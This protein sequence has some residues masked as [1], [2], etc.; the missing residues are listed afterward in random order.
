MIERTKGKHVFFLV[1]FA[2]AIALIGGGGIASSEYATI[3]GESPEECTPIDGGE[4]ETFE[5]FVEYDIGNKH[6][7]RINVMVKEDPYGEPTKVID[8]SDRS[9]QDTVSIEVEE[10]IDPDWESITLKATVYAED[11]I[12]ASGSDEVYYPVSGSGWTCDPDPERI[13]GQV[14]DGDGNDPPAGIV[15]VQSLDD[16]EQEIQEYRTDSDCP[17]CFDFDD[18]SF[19]TPGEYR[20]HVYGSDSGYPPY[21]GYMDFTLDEG[22]S[23]FVSFE[24]GGVFSTDLRVTDESG[25]TTDLRFGPGEDVQT[26]LDVQ[27]PRHG[28]D[29][30][31]EMY[32]YETGGERGSHPDE[33]Y[34]PP[35]LGAG[36][37]SYE[38]TFDAPDEEGTYEVKYR[39]VTEF[40]DG[41]ESTTDIVEGP[42][43]EV[44]A[45]EPPHIEESTPESETV[46]I[47]AKEDLNFSVTASDPDTPDE[48]LSVVWTVDDQRVAS[49]TSF[50]FDA[51]AYE[52]GDHDVRVLVSDGLDRTEDVE[53]IWT[54]EVIEPPQIEDVEPG[55]AEVLAGEQ[56]ILRAEATDPGDHTPLSYTWRID[57]KTYQGSEVHHRFTEVGTQEVELRVKNSRDVETERT[58]NV[59]VKSPPEFEEWTPEQSTVTGVMSGESLSFSVDA[60]DPEG[61][62]VTYEWYV[63]DEFASSGPEFT[64]HFQQ[65]GNYEVTAVVSDSHGLSVER[66]WSVQVTSFRQDPTV[67]DHFTGTPDLDDRTAEFFTV[68]FQNPEVND[69]DAHVEILVEV[70]PGIIVSEAQRV[71]DGDR[72]QFRVSDIVAPD[73]QKSLAINLHVNDESLVGETVKV[74]YR[75]IYY[76]DGNKDDHVVVSK[77]S[78]EVQ[79]GD[80]TTPTAAPEAGTAAESMGGT[81]AETPGFT[82]T[83]SVASILLV[84]AALR[85]FRPLN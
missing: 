68:S 49:D 39:I 2:V 77:E 51:S 20:V 46:D 3:L 84:L 34:D 8:I 40:E 85:R 25:S 63:D 41:A 50:T 71:E 78:S 76:P 26:H 64:Y 70:P 42:S 36:P 74:D 24:R 17:G 37:N 33:V 72:S 83:I 10:Y 54:V 15:V 28:Q 60:R 27:K 6:P 35:H 57:G 22:D 32:V 45:Y 18:Q 48:E 81:D 29:V 53:L 12:V 5:F 9:N 67:R 75:L 52:P 61:G 23:E 65:R 19:V 62:D 4:Y 43:F 55:S 16:G 80:E 59:T 47:S 82:V 21:W 31:I 79:L 1:A 56:M 66:S 38:F 30:E 14:V 7:D 11:E 44:R 69:R 13:S 58:V 73:N